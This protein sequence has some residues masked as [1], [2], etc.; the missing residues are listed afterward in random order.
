MNNYCTLRNNFLRKNLPVHSNYEQIKNRSLVKF[1]NDEENVAGTYKIKIHKKIKMT[2]YFS[3][4]K[5]FIKI[6]FIIAVKTFF[7][8][9]LILYKI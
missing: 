3:Y 4:I 5:K 1:K 8:T 2:K 7:N 9:N 6:C